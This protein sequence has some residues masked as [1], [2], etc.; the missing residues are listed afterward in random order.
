MNIKLSLSIQF[1]LIVAAILGVASYFIYENSATFRHTEFNERL[2]EKGFILAELILEEDEIDTS[3]LDAVE[4]NNLNFLPEQRIYLY[5]HDKKLSYSSSFEYTE[6]EKKYLDVIEKKNEVHFDQDDAE[7]AGFYFSHSKGKYYVLIGAADESGHRKLDYLWRLLLEIFIASMFVTGFLGWF[8]AKQSL[9]PMVMVNREVE[10]ITAKNLFKRLKVGKTKDEIAKLAMTFNKM[11]DR[12]ESSFIIQK[13]FVSNASHE[14]R[15]P[16]TSMKGQIE[17]TLM[18][19]RSEED[20]IHTLTSINEDVS[21]LIELLQGLNDLAKI[22]VEFMAESYE[23]LPVLDI[24]FDTRSDLLRNK[25]SYSIDF[26]IHEITGEEKSFTIRGN[27]A[28]LKSAFTNLM[29]NA[30]KFS[31][32]LNVKVGIRF[33]QKV[34]ITFSDEGV[35]IAENEVNH[36][37]EPFYRGNDTRNIAGY[38]IG[39][40]LVKRIIELHNGTIEV[41]SVQGVGTTF[42]VLLPGFDESFSDASV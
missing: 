16:L 21:H 12:L 6:P 41:K 20:Y 39:L 25:P 28:L 37:F 26:D 35:G 8:F 22:N 2:K 11:L 13:N 24:L 31:P 3:F 30:C 4:R 29:D 27:Y 15:T 23:R 40:S 19:E 10:Q 34:M 17:V 1:S 7:F 14:F 32:N 36:I 38:G 18:K 5:D 33:N 42:T 9:H